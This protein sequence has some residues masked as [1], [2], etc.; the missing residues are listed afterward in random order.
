VA[1]TSCEPVSLDGAETLPTP[2]P[3]TNATPT[4][5]TKG[6]IPPNKLPKTVDFIF[7]NQSLSKTYQILPS[8]TLHA[9]TFKHPLAPVAPQ[10]FL[11]FFLGSI[12]H[13]SF[14]PNFGPCLFT[15]TNA[16]STTVLPPPPPPIL[17][18]PSV[19]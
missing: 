5:A 7:F 9:E 12:G 15:G 13:G 1:S 16:S 2:K 6:T 4:E 11:N 19:G 17:I 3:T 10:Q 14:R 8:F 18:E